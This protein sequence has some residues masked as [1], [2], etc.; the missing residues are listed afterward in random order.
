[1]C[2]GTAICS[3]QLSIRQFVFC[4]SSIV[5]LIDVARMTIGVSLSAVCKNIL[6][7][8]EEG[9]MDRINFHLEH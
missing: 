6:L 7:T 3:L 2:P 1:M 4:T 9:R 8:V 5:K